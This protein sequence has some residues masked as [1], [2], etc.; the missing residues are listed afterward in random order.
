MSSQLVEVSAS[1]TQLV[2]GCG[3]PHYALESAGQGVA[4]AQ[5]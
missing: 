3:E 2:T 1:A 5:G 4:N